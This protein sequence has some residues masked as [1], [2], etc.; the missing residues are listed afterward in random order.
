MKIMVFAFMDIKRELPAVGS[1][2]P[3]PADGER[4]PRYSAEPSPGRIALGPA[5]CGAAGGEGAAGRPPRTPA[6]PRAGAAAGSRALPV[7]LFYLSRTNVTGKKK[8]KYIYISISIYMYIYIS[9][10]GGL[11]R[12]RCATSPGAGTHRHKHSPSCSNWKASQPK[13]G[14]G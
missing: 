11:S 12:G 4:R 9:L 14:G 6:L 5:R 2:R 7:L 3:Q 8:N 10:S 13:P 1:V